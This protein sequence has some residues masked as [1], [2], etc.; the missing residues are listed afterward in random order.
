MTRQLPRLGLIGGSGMLGRAI[1][2]AVLDQGVIA[3]NDLWIA[4]RSGRLSGLEHHPGVRVTTELHPLVSSCDI[5]LLAVPPAQASAVRFKAGEALVISVMAGVTVERLSALTGTR[6]VVRAMSSPA[7]AQGLAYSPWF[8]DEDVTATDRGHVTT[9]FEACGKTD[10]VPDEGQI[11]IF[12]A[13]TGPV[14]G[15]VAYLATC[16]TD[17]AIARG[18]APNIA[19]RAVRQLFLASGQAMTLSEKTPAVHVDEMIA[20]A[21]TTAAGLEVL[22][23]SPLAAALAQGLDAAVRKSREI[24]RE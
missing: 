15:F 17:Y 11:D 21:G 24:N 16:M 12:T 10:A 20:Y 5:I 3:P 1:A 23:T 2:Q 9:L 7:A 19:D 6:R 22:R 4:N 14:P 18:I 13:L 8:A